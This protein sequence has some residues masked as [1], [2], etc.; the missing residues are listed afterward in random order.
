MGG[1]SA[2]SVPPIERA[3]MGEGGCFLETAGVEASAAPR[4]PRASEASRMN[5]GVAHS[6]VN[7]NTRVMNSRGIWLA[8]I[9][10]VGLLHVVLLSIPFFS[11]PV[12]WTLTNVIHNLAMYVFLHTVKGTPFETPDQG[13]ARL[14][15]HWEQMD[16]G[17]QFTSSRKFLSISPIVLYLLASFYTKYDA[18]HFLI[19]TA[20]L[21]SVL[22]PKLPQFHGVRLF[23]INKY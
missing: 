3:Q 9:I 11:I 15:T 22:L 1:G 8:Y 10:L 14:L 18:A 7:P 19:N 13:K 5:V 20:S 6:E 4:A 21:L 2:D 23:G 17:L 16:Y 12:V